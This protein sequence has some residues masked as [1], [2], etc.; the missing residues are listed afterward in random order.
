L[1][2]VAPGDTP[3]WASVNEIRSKFIDLDRPDGP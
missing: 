1:S 2:E 3:K